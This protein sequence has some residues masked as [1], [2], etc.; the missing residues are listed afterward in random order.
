MRVI[1]GQLWGLL[2]LRCQRISSFLPAKSLILQTTTT[3]LLIYVKIVAVPEF[4][5]R[6][7]MK[8]TWSRRRH[9]NWLLKRDP[10]IPIPASLGPTFHELIVLIV[11]TS[12][13]KT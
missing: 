11:Q 5:E 13:T 1:P 12:V 2:N 10:N 7:I 3:H 9:A 4:T 6:L 8:R